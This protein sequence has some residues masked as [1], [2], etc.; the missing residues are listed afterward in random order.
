MKKRGFFKQQYTLDREQKEL[1]VE[2]VLKQNVGPLKPRQNLWYAVATVDEKPYED[3][4]L[5][6]TVNAQYEAEDIG[7]KVLEEMK[8]KFK[9]EGKSFRLK[10]KK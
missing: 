10:R 6:F 1:V 5:V 7:E 9:A 8:I 3:P 4:T 2:V